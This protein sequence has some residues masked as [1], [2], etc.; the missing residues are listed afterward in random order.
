MQ[1]RNPSVALDAPF[2]ATGAGA[3]LALSLPAAHNRQRRY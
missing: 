3:Y 2:T 1:L